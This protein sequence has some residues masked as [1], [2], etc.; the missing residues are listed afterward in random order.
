MMRFRNLFWLV[1]AV[2]VAAGCGGGGS[3]PQHNQ[4]A[5]SITA[6]PT[7]SAIVYGQALTSSSL[8]GGTA[9]VAGTFSWT[10]P[11]TVPAAGTQSESVTFTPSDTNDYTTATGSVT[12][13]VNQ[14]TPTITWSAPAAI[15]YGTAL[16]AS[17]LDATAN[18]GGSF[19][20]SPASGTV[21]P[22]GQQ[23]LSVAFAPT[24][25]T[26][27]TGATASVILTVDPA[28]P[29]IAWS[30]PAS[31]TYGTA[32]SATQLDATAT[33]SSGTFTYTPASGT[34][35]TAGQHVLSVTFS[36]TNSTDYTAASDSV[37]L[38]VSQAT[39]TVA[40]WPTASA[41]TSGQTLSNSALTGGSASVPGTFA[42][43]TS[44]DASTTVPAAGTDSYNVTFTPTDSVDYATVTESVSV[45]VNAPG[46]TVDFGTTYQTIDG[47][48]GST[49]WLGQMP[50]AVATALYSPTNGLGLS[51]LRVRI[52]YEGSPSGGG[53][54]GMPYETG[55]SGD[56][57]GWDFELV[58]GM[59]A[60][61]NNPHAK[62]FATPWTPPLSMKTSSASEPY[63]SGSCSPAGS[64]GGYLNPSDYAA[65]AAYLADFVN[66]FNSNSGGINL[67]A[68]SMQ[69]EPDYA[70]VGYESCYWTAD[71]MDAFVASLSGPNALGARLIMPESFQFLPAQASPTLNDPSAVGNVSIVGG[72]IY[73]VQPSA[74]PFPSGVSLPLWMTEYGPANGNT[75]TFSSVVTTYGESIHDAMVNGQYNAYVWWG[76]FGGSVGS[77]AT[78]AGSYGLVDYAG[79]QTV[80]GWVFGQYSKFIQPG[81]VRAS[82]TANPVSGVYVS[83]YEY[84]TG[85]TN[86]YNNTYAIV[87]I[88]ANATAQPISFTVNNGSVTSLTPYQSTSAAGLQAQ[89]AVSVTGG[90][91]TYTL[92]AQSITTFVQ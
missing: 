69:N 11:A 75:P 8:T 27:Y 86:P 74:Y 56:P 45:T 65:Y 47:F 15:A 41:I 44:D 81:F 17:Q 14:A 22:V 26:D 62:V 29:T 35:L 78:N 51:I 6:W 13:T 7:A 71:Q 80:A 18:T 87:V 42:W 50:P 83:A 10:T 53:K 2:L 57:S 21:L 4:V 59:E 77:G 46:V 72:H 19:S 52:D 66:F 23:T 84:P 40:T 31:I 85:G 30:T 12:L 61:A 43:S 76:V 90:Q 1:S 9:S 34:V 58:N 5:P 36:P 32:L 70:D 48:G 89:S 67:Y 3:S 63:Y 79:N 54:Y 55:G 28:T 88:N 60:V 24:D 82:A 33:P 73:G 38:T 64:C 68:I 39:P 25:S 91:F 92:P 49:A 37:N 16:S 20:Y